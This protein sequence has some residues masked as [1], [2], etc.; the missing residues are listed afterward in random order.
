MCSRLLSVLLLALVLLPW[1]GRSVPV[2]AQSLVET[3]PGI[4]GQAIRSGLFD[5]QAALL[6]G[7]PVRVVEPVHRLL[8]TRFGTAAPA[9]FLDGLPAQLKTAL[10]SRGA[11]SGPGRWS[12][13]GFAANPYD[14]EM[15]CGVLFILESFVALKP[16]P[17][18]PAVSPAPLPLTGTL[19]PPYK[20]A[21]V[22]VTAP[23]GETA[24][25]PTRPSGERGP[26]EHFAVDLR[27]ERPGQYQI[28]VLGADR[29]GPTVLANF[30]LYCGTAP[31][32]FAALVS[33]AGPMASPSSPA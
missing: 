32:D 28:E 31:K 33:A 22:V 23:G 30:P 17:R 1:V 26:G 2:G 27:C 24:A 8:L 18:N 9:D 5:A 4:T 25:L 20:G 3:P 6:A 10:G 16:P 19:L 21:R 15:S 7:D 14:A 12:R 29:A 11:G 13:Y